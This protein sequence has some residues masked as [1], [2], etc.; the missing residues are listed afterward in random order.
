MCCVCVADRLD[1]SS[2]PS[3]KIRMLEQKRK[4]ISSRQITLMRRSSRVESVLF[5]EVEGEGCARWCNRQ[6]KP[7]YFFGSVAGAQGR[8]SSCLLRGSSV[9]APNHMQVELGQSWTS[10]VVQQQLPWD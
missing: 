6:P 9:E 3:K 7:G 8:L 10:I 2:A 1:P 5:L 4:A